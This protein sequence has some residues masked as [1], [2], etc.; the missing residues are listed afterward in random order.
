MPLDGVL[1]RAGE[2]TERDGGTLAALAVALR[3]GALDAQRRPRV[4]RPAPTHDSD[5]AP[6]DD[7]AEAARGPSDLLNAELSVLEFNTRVLALAEDPSIPLLERLRFVAIVGGNVDEFFAVRVAELRRELAERPHARSADGL[8][9]REQLEAIGWRVPALVARQHQTLRECLAALE[10]H[11][12]RIR[13]WA[14]LDDAERGWLR[15]QYRDEILAALTPLAITLSPGHPIPRISHLTLALALVVR[16]ETSGRAHFAEVELP[17]GTSRFLPLPGGSEFVALEDVIRENLDVLYPEGT[18]ESAH[19]FRLTRGGDLD[20]ADS[21]VRDLLPAVEEAAHRRA[22]NPIVRI[23]VERGMPPLLREL[24]LAELGN[25]RGSD[26]AP[27]T[28]SDVYEVDWPL[29]LRALGTIADLPRPELR[30]APFRARA[31]IDESR[32]IFDALR[33]GDVLAHHP[34][35][36]FEGTAGRLVSEAAEDPLRTGRS[37]EIQVCSAM[38]V[39]MAAT[40]PSTAGSPVTYCT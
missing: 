19:C 17:S 3:A 23:E 34:W 24:L 8:T 27:L 16:D 21:G 18:V 10:A 9:P 35:D 13:R 37:P 4:V 6:R 26:G 28:P 31:P 20:L 40:N 2:A 33:D 1:A 39:T 36:S 15:D 29:D 5:G 25:E 14:D 7:D 22:V 30:F 32:S 12:I 11:G 38:P